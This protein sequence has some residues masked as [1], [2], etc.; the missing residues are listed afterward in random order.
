MRTVK[1]LLILLGHRDRTPGGTASAIL[2]GDNV[3]G[4]LMGDGT[5]YILMGS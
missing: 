4:I 5:S 1:K 2:L 3:S